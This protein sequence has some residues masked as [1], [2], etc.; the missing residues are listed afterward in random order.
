MY[1]YNIKKL[2]LN[3]EYSIEDTNKVLENNVRNYFKMI[4]KRRKGY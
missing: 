2:L 1:G 4:K 3:N